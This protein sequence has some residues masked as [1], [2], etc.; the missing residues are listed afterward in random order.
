[1]QRQGTALQFLIL[2]TFFIGL[3][4]FS[5]NYAVGV[6]EHIVQYNMLTAL[7]FLF[8]IIISYFQFNEL[9]GL[10][11]IRYRF[12]VQERHLVN[13]ESIISIIRKE[14]HDFANHLNTIHAICTHNKPDSIGRVKQYINILGLELKSSY[15][16]YST[17]NDY[18][19]GLLAVKSNE[20]FVKNINFEVEFT[21]LLS[22][23]KVKDHILV[24]IISN[25][26]DNALEAFTEDQED[27]VISVL[28]SVESGKY[29]I[30]ISDNGPMIPPE[31]I[32]KIFEK[33]FTTKCGYKKC[34]HGFGLF[35]TAQLI[36][37][38]KGTVK[39]NSTE[40]ETEF[41]V[42]FDI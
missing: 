4:V 3:L 22:V 8:F 35:I 20:A 34:D 6:K 17:G 14:K 31:I 26:V 10:M 38:N 33:G 40:Y 39:V 2:Q 24:S 42:F 15:H 18:V 37:S 21:D 25:I 19:D 1:M 7:L 5:L 30:S 29:C 36:H 12:E 28:G 9:I 41:Q 16:F 32:D 13:M 27:K 11:N 23:L